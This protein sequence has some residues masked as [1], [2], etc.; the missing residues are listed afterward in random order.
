MY[1]FKQLTDQTARQRLSAITQGW[2]GAPDDTNFNII[3]RTLLQQKPI[4]AVIER[5]VKSMKELQQQ[6][7][8]D[9]IY[10]LQ[11]SAAQTQKLAD[12]QEAKA[13]AQQASDDNPDLIQKKIQFSNAGIVQLKQQQDVLQTSLNLERQN[14]LSETLQSLINQALLNQ[15]N[16]DDI[17]AAADQKT[18]D[19][20]SQLETILRDLE[21]QM[22]LA[23]QKQEQCEKAVKDRLVELQAK[24]K[25]DQKQLT[26]K[27]GQSILDYI[28]F[29]N[30]ENR[31]KKLQALRKEESSAS[32]HLSDLETRISTIQQD[33]KTRPQ[34]DNQRARHHADRELRKKARLAAVAQNLVQAWFNI[35]PDAY[36]HL[37]AI[38][39]QQLSAANFRG[40]QNAIQQAKNS[41]DTRYNHKLKDGMTQ[42]NSDIQTHQL[43]I[44]ALNIQSS[45][46]AGREKQRQ[47]NADNRQFRQTIREQY[48]VPSISDVKWEGQ[49]SSK[50]KE[51]LDQQIMASRTAVNQRMSVCLTQAREQSWPVLV[52]I[53]QQLTWSEESSPARALHD[54]ACQ[55]KKYLQHQNNVTHSEC[56]LAKINNEINTI[57]EKMNALYDQ[58]HENK[59]SSL[60]VE[61]TITTASDKVE[62]LETLVHENEKLVSLNGRYALLN[63]VL[64]AASWVFGGLVIGGALPTVSVLAG[65]MAIMP[66]GYFGVQGFNRFRQWSFCF[67]NLESN[68][69]DLKSS[70]KSIQNGEAQ[71]ARL[72]TD[73]QV[74]EQNISSLQSRMTNLAQSAED[75]RR[76]IEQSQQ[77]ASETLFLAQKITPDKSVTELLQQSAFAPVAPVSGQTIFNTLNVPV[78]TAYPVDTTPV[79]AVERVFV[80]LI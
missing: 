45:G 13:D 10:Q 51:L 71:L 29:G 7:M 6:E 11:L 55:L 28:N 54:I 32:S 47:I 4:A 27:T 70:E 68:R 36:F 39:Q 60:V 15:V 76:L 67:K 22:P 8:H 24:H 46:I 64:S 72:N 3:K 23:K 44:H 35:K 12:E 57:Q 2:L 48:P 59:A 63:G 19:K 43:T 20:D 38:V 26:Q 25:D 9:M 77:Q 78:A 62:D 18:A 14:T 37:H 49:L 16:E 80:N 58:I 75:T 69:T 1:N 73:N 34:R 65:I 41:A 74:K 52:E 42:L 33:I 61:S 21:N 31:D 5:F 40:L 53:V 66:G 30:W 56:K 79:V 17:A 50:T